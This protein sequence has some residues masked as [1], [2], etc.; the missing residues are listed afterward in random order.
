MKKLTDYEM[1]ILE[2]LERYEAEHYLDELVA[3]D[4]DVND[5][6][7]IIWAYLTFNKHFKDFISTMKSDILTSEQIFN[8]INRPLVYENHTDKRTSKSDKPRTP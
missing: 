2:I 3:L 5:V 4:V 8:V 7:N 6:E 1:E